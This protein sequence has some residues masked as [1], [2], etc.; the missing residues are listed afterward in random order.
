MHRGLHWSKQEAEVLVKLPVQKIYIRKVLC[1]TKSV[2]ANLVEHY[3]R[4]YQE[5]A[6]QC[7]NVHISSCRKG[8]KPCRC[9]YCVRCN[10][11]HPGS[12][13]TFKQM[14][15]TSYCILPRHTKEYCGIETINL[16]AS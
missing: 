12:A 8:W 16:V 2:S 6:R 10:R 15:C 4:C 7:I 13:I 3:K 1:K 11:E 14:L 5:H 9:G